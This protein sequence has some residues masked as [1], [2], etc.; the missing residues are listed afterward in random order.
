MRTVK[1]GN[2]ILQVDD[3]S[4]QQYLNTG[5]DEIDGAGNVIT[6]GAVNDINILRR[7][8][9]DAQAKIRELE[10]KL[11]RANAK[12]EKVEKPKPVEDDKP[13]TTAK[14]K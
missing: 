7:K 8:Y 11:A 4:L 3:D 5:F 9:A 14:K 6:E 12:P 1:R 13:K 2:V 10:N